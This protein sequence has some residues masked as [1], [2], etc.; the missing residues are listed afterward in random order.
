MEIDPATLS[1][2]D[3]YRTLI[4]CVIPRPIGWISTISAE[5]HVN[6]A[7]FSFFGGVTTS[8]P[9]VM[10]SVGRRQGQPKD[11]GANLLA[12]RECVVHIPH[13][14]LAEAMV[15]T[16]AELAPDEDEFAYAGLHQVPSSLVKPPR[17]QEAAI[18][19]EARVA[20]H[21]EIG[22]GPVDVFF[23]EILRLHLDDAI[24][25]DGLPDAS[26]LGAVGRL[27][28]ADYCDTSNVFPIARD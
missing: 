5:G 8:P 11:T 9:T 18:A 23:L 25:V 27:G 1:P 22:T 14:P 26:R 13:R 7:P 20:Q 24:L 15:K 16:S 6:L 17:V 12:T 10:L 28:G 3:A 19:M 4:A 21:L 2:R